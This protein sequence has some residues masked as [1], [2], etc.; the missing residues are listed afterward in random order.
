MVTFEEEFPFEE[1]EDQLAAVSNIKQD[2]MSNKVMDRLI[3]GDVGYGKTE[4][5]PPQDRLPIKTI[6]TESS[7]TVLKNALLRELSR[8]GQVFIIHNRVE[9]IY[10][11]M[12]RV[13]TLLLPIKWQPGMQATTLP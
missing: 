4:V 8:D 12:T 7:D 13:K 2:M 3:C 1:T 9:T 10:S 5:K 11:V 6:I